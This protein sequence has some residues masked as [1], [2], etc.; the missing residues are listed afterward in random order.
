MDPQ[1]KCDLVNSLE[2]HLAE[3]THGQSANVRLLWLLEI[4]YEY[5]ERWAGFFGHTPIDTAFVDESDLH[6]MLLIGVDRIDKEI[7]S[8]PSMA[9]DSKSWKLFRDFLSEPRRSTSAEVAAKLLRSFNDARS[10]I[11][12]KQNDL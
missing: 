3:A 5:L 6:Q 9:G 1:R 2:S 4:V 8:I 12:S 10:E 11:I 7:S